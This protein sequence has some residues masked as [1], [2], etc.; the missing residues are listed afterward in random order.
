ME[1]DATQVRKIILDEHCVLRDELQEIGTLL[2]DVAVQRADATARLRLR[3]MAFYSAFLK[4]IAHEESLLRPVLRDIDAWGPVRVERMDEEH[5][6]QRATIVALAAL[7][8]AVDLDAFLGRVKAFVR[9]VERD[10]ADE[11]RECLSPEVL[12]DDTIVID[13]F[14]G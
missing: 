9:E 11:E 3:L 1:L 12:R 7:D 13:T 14:T 8:P 5:R 4:H 10:M 2:D 6:Q